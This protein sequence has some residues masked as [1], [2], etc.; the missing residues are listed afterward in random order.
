MG[1]ARHLLGDEA[2]QVGVAALRRDR[3]LQLAW[4]RLARLTRGLE[5]ARGND[6]AR[7]A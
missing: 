6:E 1:V 7:A 5:G 3:R 2:W 4:Q